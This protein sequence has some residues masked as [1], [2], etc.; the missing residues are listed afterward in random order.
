M[1]YV[2]KHPNSSFWTAVYLDHFNCWRKK[3][4]KQKACG[5]A[6]ELALE[7][8]RTAKL[9][10]EHLLT[11]NK[12]R[13]IIAGTLERTT[14]EKLQH[15]TFKAFCADWLKGKSYSRQDGTS[16]RYAG[17]VD[18]LLKFLASKANFPIEVITPTHCQQ[19]HDFLL[20]SRL[21]PAAVRVELQTISA[22][23]NMRA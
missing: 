4:T 10:R 15:T 2:W 7:W 14:G 3:T 16:T 18:K 9:G 5:K 20:E 11:E 19:F 6:F 22:I 21:A 17:S 13:E 23:F 12:S 1:A 8:E